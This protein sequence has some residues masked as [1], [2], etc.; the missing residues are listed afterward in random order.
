MPEKP[1]VYPFTPNL[2]MEY[3]SYLIAWCHLKASFQKSAK[4]DAVSCAFCLLERIGTKTRL[5]SHPYGF[6][7]NH[8]GRRHNH[9]SFN[10]IF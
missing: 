4:N 6:C 3:Q 10:E 9:Q 7:A 2:E 1:P 8:G 5:H